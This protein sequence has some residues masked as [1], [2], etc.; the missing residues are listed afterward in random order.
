MFEHLRTMNLVVLVRVE[1]LSYMTDHYGDEQ[2]ISISE[3]EALPEC[4]KMALD[5]KVCPRV[6]HWYKV[7][8]AAVQHETNQRKKEVIR[9]YDLLNSL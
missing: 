4:V 1:D 3:Y 9:E 5:W 6:R 7:D 2:E 8:D